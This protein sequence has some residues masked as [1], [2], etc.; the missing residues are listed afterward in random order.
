MCGV[1]SAVWVCGVRCAECGVH[2]HLCVR[3]RVHV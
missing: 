2:V 1:R 3:V